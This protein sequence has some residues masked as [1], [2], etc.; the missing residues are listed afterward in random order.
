MTTPNSCIMGKS[1]FSVGEDFLIT[2]YMESP[3]QL[4]F[5]LHALG[6]P[7]VPNTMSIR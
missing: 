7:S 6:L 1:H 5:C 4:T 2:A 3:H